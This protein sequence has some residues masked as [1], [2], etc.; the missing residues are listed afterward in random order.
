M[1]QVETVTVHV[2]DQ[3]GRAVNGGGVLI[4]VDGQTVAASALGGGFFSATVTT[5]LFNFATMGDFFSS[6]TLVA[7]YSDAG[8]ALWTSSALTVEQGIL[9][10]YFSELL[11]ALTSL[12]RGYTLFVG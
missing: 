11:A 10:D 8:S 2:T 1:T 6:H 3:F 12:D 9:F 4:Q 5:S 7:S